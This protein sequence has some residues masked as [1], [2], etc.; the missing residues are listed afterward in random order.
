MLGK[1]TLNY[2]PNFT[3]RKRNK[4]NIRY[5]VFHYTGM[6][7]ESKAI[8]RLTNVSSKVSCHYYIKRNGQ[9][10][11]L[12]PELYIAWHAGKSN[13]KKDNF[14]NKYSIGIEIS[15]K[16]HQ[17]GYEKFSKFQIKSLIYLSRY[18]IKKYNIKKNYILGHSDISFDRK[19]IL[20]KSFHGNIL[21][22]KEWVFGIKSVKKN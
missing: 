16:G 14:L 15:N 13:W 2:S 8:K 10:I 11:L 21:Q 12:V 22:K 3:T 17:F 4:Q 1:T 18:L 6:K 7:S 20:V 9:I 19:K 5:L